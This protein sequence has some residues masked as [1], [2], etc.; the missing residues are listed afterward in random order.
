MGGQLLVYVLYGVVYFSYFASFFCLD[1]GF[2]LTLF[3]QCVHQCAFFFPFPDIR[4][5]Q[6][7]LTII[8]QDHMV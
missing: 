3:L 1:L 7:F 5:G 2:L 8:L 4:G 6:N